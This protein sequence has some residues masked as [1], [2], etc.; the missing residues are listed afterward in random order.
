MKILH[1]ADLHL[2]SSMTSVLPKEKARDRR[3][4][5]LTSYTNIVRYAVDNDIHH[6]IIAGDMFDTKSVSA[7]ARN[8]VV[9]SITANPDITFY[10]LKGNHDNDSFLG[11]LENVPDNLK[12]FA[13][14]WTSYDLADSNVSIYGLEISENRDE[15]YHGLIL[16]KSKYNIVVLHGQ[17]NVASGKDKEAVIN[18]RELKNK[19]ID[20]LALGHVHTHKEEKLDER[21]IYCYCGTPEGRGFDE[22]GAMGFVVLDIDER[23]HTAN[24]TFVSRNIRRLHNVEV[25]ISDISD[26]DEAIGEIRKNL[27]EYDI[28]AQDLVKITLTGKVGI[29]ADINTVVI[30]K[31]FEDRFYLFRI[32]DETTL[33]VNYEDFLL[34]ESLK[35][36]FV[37]LVKDSDMSEEMKAEVIKTGIGALL[38]EEI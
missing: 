21:G 13:N 12:L 1:C 4:E 38:K 24:L 32:K 17:E 36:E 27:D 19:N 20:Y 8:V 6:I 33:K 31:M 30:N 26:T 23:E 9:G 3:G 11:A 10:Y 22:C 7:T 35:G 25:D 16:D 37:R 14:E 29:D 28:P 15:L 5:L 34:D 18:L 2:D